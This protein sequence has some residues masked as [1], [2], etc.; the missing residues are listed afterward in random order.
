MEQGLK[1]WEVK[2]AKSQLA[3]GVSLAAIAV[4]MLGASAQAQNV[5]A[6]QAGG[7]FQRGGGGHHH[8]GGGGGNS[9]AQVGA[10]DPGVRGGAPTAGQPLPGISQD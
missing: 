8:S 7:G 10:V 9:N 6:A 3:Y 4:V 2:M 1:G 5:A